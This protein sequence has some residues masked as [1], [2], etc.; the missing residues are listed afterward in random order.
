MEVSKRFEQ[1]INKLYN[2]FHNDTLHPECCKQCAVGN[3]LDGKDSWKHLS[4][5]HGATT[6]NYLGQVHQNLGRTFNGYSPIELLHIEAT[7]LKGCGYI[8]P[9]HHKNKRPKHVT[10]KDVLFL[11]LTAVVSYLCE[12]DKRHDVMDCTTLFNYCNV[13]KQVS[14]L[15]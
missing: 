1:A 14:L 4:D 9:L 2:A 6:L 11:G 7:F 5:N 8:I 3:I 15:S 12:L 13:I 10:D